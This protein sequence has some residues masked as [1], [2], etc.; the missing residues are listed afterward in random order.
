[1]LTTNQLEYKLVEVTVDGKKK[2][3]V[4]LRHRGTGDSIGDDGMLQ[5]ICQWTL[6][7]ALLEDEK[8][9]QGREDKQKK[10][11]N[12]HTRRYTRY[13]APLYTFL[14]PLVWPVR[15]GRES[16]KRYHGGT[17]CTPSL[18]PSTRGPS[19]TVDGTHDRFTSLGGTRIVYYYSLSSR[20]SILAVVDRLQ[21]LSCLSI[22]I[23]PLN[24]F[25]EVSYTFFFSSHR[26]TL[27][28]FF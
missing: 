12:S 26:R 27:H 16:K 10:N 4:R 3:L 22:A 13:S 5:S 7:V 15:S 24:R 23:S 17:L 8:R 18:P 28:F 14:S 11:K 9:S 20:I 6:D 2:Y 21:G 1:M 19:C 25:G